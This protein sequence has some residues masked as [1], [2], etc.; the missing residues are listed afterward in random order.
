MERTTEVTGRR[1][2]N[3]SYYVQDSIYAKYN[4]HS[5]FQ[6]TSSKLKVLNTTTLLHTQKYTA[7]YKRRFTN[8]WDYRKTHIGKKNVSILN[9]KPHLIGR[10]SS[11]VQKKKKKTSI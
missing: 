3:N 1:R 11:I 10:Y 4:L 8:Y 6:I 9:L 2:D 5:D 7:K